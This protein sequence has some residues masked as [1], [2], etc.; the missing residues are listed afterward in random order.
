M[1]QL[2]QLRHK[3]RS[4]QT[5]KKITHAV[6]LISMSLYGKL[7]KINR[8]LENYTNHIQELF[9]E[10]LQQAPETWHSELL[11]PD[12]LLDNRPLYIV[13]GTSKGLCG[14]LNSNMF[15]FLETSLIIEKNQAPAF[16][17]VGLRAIAALKEKKMGELVCSYAD[18]NSNNFLAVA[19]DI[20]ERIVEAPIRYSSVTFYHNI[21]KSFFVQMPK[22]ST[23]IP[24]SHDSLTPSKASIDTDVIWEQNKTTILD[25]LSVCYLRCA[26]THLLFESLRAEHAARFLAMENSNNNAEKYLERL[27]LQFNKT[28]QASITREVSELSVSFPAR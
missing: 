20:I 5:T 1:S 27:T 12:D 2:V 22:K 19:D 18:L 24:V 10:T 11:F 28:R 7:E 13:I 8:P 6:R 17:A 16:I 9:L 21:T 15:A 23:L 3:I 4:I 25:Y 14:G 26:I